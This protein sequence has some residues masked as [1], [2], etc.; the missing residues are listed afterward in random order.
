MTAVKKWHIG[1][2]GPGPCSARKIACR[3]SDQPHG[4]EKAMTLV[5]ERSLEEEFGDSEET[6]K[7]MLQEYKAARSRRKFYSEDYTAEEIR[8]SMNLSSEVNTEL[9]NK[10]FK[11]FDRR[12]RSNGGN[13]TVERVEFTDGTKAYF[14]PLIVNNASEYLF[15]DY[16]TTSSSAMAA[17]ANA[18]RLAQA[19]GGEFSNLVPETTIRAIDGQVGSVQ[20]E[21]MGVRHFA[22]DLK[23]WLRPSLKADARRAA[24]FDFVSGNLDRHEENFII[25]NEASL[26]DGVMKRQR[27]L[28]LIDN[29]FS[30]KHE[31][32]MTYANHFSEYDNYSGIAANLENKHFTKEEIKALKNAKKAVEVWK[33]DR[34]ISRSDANQTISRID[35]LLKKG[36]PMVYREFLEEENEKRE[37]RRSKQD[38][39][40]DEEE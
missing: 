37:V 31:G 19:F 33:K 11:K 18:Y 28:K 17:E 6:Q 34:T 26:V 32:T 2:N 24:I 5:W 16:W 9:D 8:V 13:S 27:R 38:E 20:A 25:V 7:T 22:D 3:Y 15:E 23:S 35:Y 40:L 29:A 10:E 4:S 1:L 30:F 39:A 14:K 21:V 36:K 12:F